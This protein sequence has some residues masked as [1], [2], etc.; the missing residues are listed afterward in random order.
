MPRHYPGPASARPPHGRTQPWGRLW[1]QLLL[2]PG[3]VAGALSR[4]QRGR[5]APDAKSCSGHFCASVSL[6]N[7]VATPIIRPAPDDAKEHLALNFGG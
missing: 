3:A 5:N 2:G 7:S 4:T 1:Q 6:A